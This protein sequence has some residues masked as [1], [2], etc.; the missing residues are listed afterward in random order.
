MKYA[1]VY[2]NTATGYSGYVPDLPGCITTGRSL[3]E[4]QVKMREAIRGHIQAMRQHGEAI[5]SARDKKRHRD[6]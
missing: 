1:V 5:P 2:E 3:G 6:C 4:T